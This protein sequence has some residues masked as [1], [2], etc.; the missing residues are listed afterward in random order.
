MKPMFVL[1]MGFAASFLTG[2]CSTE[3]AV[4]QQGY[5]SS[6]VEAQIDMKILVALDSGDIDKARRMAATP[7]LVDLSFLNF[8]T[9]R[10]IVSPTPEQKQEEVKLA[11]DVLDY[12]LKHRE[13]FD[14]RVPSVRSGIG[15][16][17]KILTEP[18]DVRR[19]KEL[20]DYL[21]GVEKRL[22]ETQKP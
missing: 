14:P 18:Y 4:D 3:M 8:C 13:D 20:S 1:L 6:L 17:Q 11:R 15:A 12:M 22:S 16:M 19:L 7:I 5:E 9:T 10:G 21:A 2:C